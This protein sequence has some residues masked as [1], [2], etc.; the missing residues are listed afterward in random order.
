MIMREEVREITDHSEYHLE[1][2]TTG[3][4]GDLRQGATKAGTGD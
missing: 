4:S 3:L 2:V 1:A